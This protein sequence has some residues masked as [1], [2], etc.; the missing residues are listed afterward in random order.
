MTAERKVQA[1]VDSDKENGVEVLQYDSWSLVYKVSY[2]MSVPT[3][4]T[5]GNWIFSPVFS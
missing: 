3:T 4:Q 1:P 5:M 2:A